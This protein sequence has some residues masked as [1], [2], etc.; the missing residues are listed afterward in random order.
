MNRIR[1]DYPR[2]RLTPEAYKEL[3]EQ[4]LRR[5]AW[6][7]QRCGCMSHLE[8]HHVNFRRSVRLSKLLPEGPGG[9]LRTAVY[10]ETLFQAAYPHRP[11]KRNAGA[12]TMEEASCALL[13]KNHDCSL[14]TRTYLTSSF[15]ARLI[16]LPPRT[17]LRGNPYLP[18]KCLHRKLILACPSNRRTTCRS[19]HLEKRCQFRVP[20]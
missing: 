8:V 15:G 2:V 14:K 20:W 5:D 6:R 7:C 11:A 4:V 13:A 9:R 3:H 12:P 10:G 16:S 18:C 17:H 19:G 1:P